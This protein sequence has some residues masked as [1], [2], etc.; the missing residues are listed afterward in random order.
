MGTESKKAFLVDTFGLDP[1]HIFSSRDSSFLPQILSRTSGRGVDVVL[2]SLTGDLLHE[3]FRAC[4]D[5][6]RFVEIGKRDIVEHGSLDMSTFG[7]NVSFIA[8]D[9]SNLF[10]STNSKHHTLWQKLL[11]ES[12]QFVRSGKGQ[13][14][15]PLKT[16]GASDVTQAFRHF[17]NGTR[18]GK[19]S[20]CF[21]DGRSKLS[22]VPAKYASSFSPDKTYLMIGCL[23]G[24]GRSLSRWMMS[25]G[26]RSFVF[27][28]RSG[29]DKP[30]ARDFV[31]GLERQ[32][33]Q[34][35]VVRGDVVSYEDVERAIQAARLPIGGVV[36]AAMS[37]DEAL[38]STMSH[39]S[40]HKCIRPKVTGTWNLHN[41]LR[42]DERDGQL[43]FFLM[44]SSISGTVGT[45][46]ES[47][48]CA[49]NA[50]L[51]AFARY[52]RSQGLCAVAVGLGMISEVGYLHEHPD[53]EALMKRKGI[54]AINED[55]LVQIVDFAITSP[56]QKSA[57]TLYDPLVSSHLLTGIEF[58]SLKEQRDRGF[59]GD[60]HVLT[61]PRAA[62]FAAAFERSTNG[63]KGDSGNGAGQHL[64]AEVNEALR[65]GDGSATV[66]DAVRTLVAKKISN[67]ILLPVEKL[68]PEQELGQFGLDSMLA[69]EFR[70]YV[71]QALEVDVPF[72]TLLAKNTSV[73]S[74][75]QLIVEGLMERAQK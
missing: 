61:D 48:Y 55:E 8:F 29:L 34:V 47:N 23:G 12:M 22:V 13:P 41:A 32:G 18:I 71:F 16:F 75:A 36:Q 11:Q 27:L 50:F 33:A 44:T 62:Q 35:D 43:D 52:R 66:I 65:N 39:E 6:G 58:V 40:W 74:L 26:A 10:L 63:A 28:G 3:S 25:L 64:P 56:E 60:N 2:N 59:E 20:V 46:T 72:M 73:D 49:G 14:C 38:W 53:I 15:R 67:L 42:K 57:E 31:T 51:D 69:S 5:F 68:E 1:D 30:L 70:R 4:A 7:R 9:L 24:L 45:A 19:V 21:E 37:L 17:S 54:H